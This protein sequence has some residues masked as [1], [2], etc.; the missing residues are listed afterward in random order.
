MVNLADTLMINTVTDGAMNLLRHIGVFKSQQPAPAPPQIIMKMPLWQLAQE[1]GPF[2]RLAG[3]SGAAA[4]VLGAMGAHR[5]FPEVETKEDLRKIFDT[6]NRFHFLHTLA[7]VTVPL[8][9]RPYVAGAF[10]LAGMTLFCGTCY[11]HAFTGD[12][13][14][15]R[16]TPI[17]GSC[18][19]LG[20][21]AMVL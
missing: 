7:L 13:C 2:V 11:Y 18:L 12:R 19:I 16:L 14:F 17:G 15:R 9:R 5:T 3:L 20:W 10:F 8:C 6:A 21:V 4:V 1:A